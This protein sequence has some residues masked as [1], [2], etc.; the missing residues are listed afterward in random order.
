MI[1]ATSIWPCLH[2]LNILLQELVPH[3]PP[4]RH[5]VGSGQA[6]D[7]GHSGHGQ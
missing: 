5:S 6:D 4:R 7:A 2:I 1:A 3:R